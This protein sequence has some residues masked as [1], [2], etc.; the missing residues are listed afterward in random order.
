MLTA[1]WMTF[2]DL[3]VTSRRAVTVSPS[4]MSSESFSASVTRSS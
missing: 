4:G 2:F 3:T 1:F